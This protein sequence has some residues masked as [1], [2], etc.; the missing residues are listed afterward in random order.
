MKA[1]NL[2]NG[3]R[4][5]GKCLKSS[6][7]CAAAFAL[8]SAGAASQAAE[9]TYVTGAPV[10]DREL[11]GAH[12]RALGEGDRA[13]APNHSDAAVDDRLVRPVPVVARGAELRDRHLRDGRGLGPSAG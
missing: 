9:I 3:E 12:R 5:M 2:K 1:M 8:A 11:L 4:K 10:G 13:Y 6:L 7:L